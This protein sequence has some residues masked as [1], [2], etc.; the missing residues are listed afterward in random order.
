MKSTHYI[1]RNLYTVLPRNSK[2]E[3]IISGPPFINDNIHWGTVYNI[4]LKEFYLKL[5]KTTR[6]KD[7]EILRGWDVH[8]LPTDLKLLKLCNLKKEELNEH[9]D[10]F[11][12]A[13]KMYV[14]ICK[15]KMSEQMNCLALSRPVQLKKCYSTNDKTYYESVW[16]VYNKLKNMDLIEYKLCT[17]AHCIYCLAGLANIEIEKKEKISQNCY[18]R[19]PVK[20]IPN[21]YILIWTTTPW[22]IVCTNGLA[23]NKYNNYYLWKT[24]EDLYYIL[25]EVPKKLEHLELKKERLITLD[26]LN[27]LI[28]IFRGTEFKLRHASWVAHTDLEEG[29]ST[30]IVNVSSAYSL[31]DLSYALEYNLVVEHFIN[32]DGYFNKYFNSNIRITDLTQIIEHLG[33]DLVYKYQTTKDVDTCYRCG[34]SVIEYAKKEYFLKV[35]E[36]VK[37]R[38]ITNNKLILWNDINYKREFEKWVSQAR[39]WCISRNRIYGVPIPEFGN[40]TVSSFA[41]LGV[42]S[43]EELYKLLPTVNH[44]KFVFDCWFQ[45]AIV[46]I[47]AN[48]INQY[49]VE[50]CDQKRGWIYTTSVLSMYILNSL[51]FKRV[52]LHG[53]LLANDKEKYSKSKLGEDYSFKEELIHIIES[54]SLEGFKMYMHSLID[55]ESV[56]FSISKVNLY[57]KKW[58]IIK[59][60]LNYLDNVVDLDISKETSD[61]DIFLSLI[62]NMCYDLDKL[63][64]KLK[65]YF[66]VLKTTEYTNEL[67]SYLVDEVSRSQLKLVKLYDKHV[68]YNLKKYWYNLLSLK[69]NVLI[70]PY[71]NLL[72]EDIGM[73]KLTSGIKNKMQHLSY[74]HIGG[75][76]LLLNLITTTLNLKK[77]ILG[78]SKNMKYR[79]LNKIPLKIGLIYSLDAFKNYN[80]LERDILLKATNTYLDTE[81]SKEDVQLRSILRYINAYIRDE[82]TKSVKLIKIRGINLDS[83]NKL[84]TL[85]Q[86]YNFCRNIILKLD[87]T[88]IDGIKIIDEIQFKGL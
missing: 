66:L 67:L 52:H 45:S 56:K 59:S 33:Q 54:N 38:I 10:R 12:A 51:P 76:S 81:Y 46:H 44:C 18:Y 32:E 6:G 64:Q 78:V 75:Y 63:Y 53:F 85:K 71:N 3:L 34:N 70:A 68:P 20:N 15:Q 69:I 82:K 27:S 13:A 79:E 57:H 9:R 39:D 16:S 26:V 25:S 19:Y 43:V 36:E 80:K 48:H 84:N 5:N 2:S 60:M 74:I 86:K 29:A 1:Y 21:T 22:T 83:L 41:Q 58:L 24:K 50:G 65:N 4:L 42:N 35:T 77:I 62:I 87:D 17:R 40:K 47:Y 72:L 37:K 73:Y 28:Y 14:D 23:Y 49:L 55:W 61:T 88:I 31:N 7:I 8:G 30:G 11:I